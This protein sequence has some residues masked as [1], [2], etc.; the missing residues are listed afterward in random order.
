MIL[1]IFYFTKKG[2]FPDQDWKNIKSYN[3]EF[4]QKSFEV[5]KS[6]KFFAKVLPYHFTTFLIVRQ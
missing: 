4:L 1:K 6:K 5:K 2:P 3:L